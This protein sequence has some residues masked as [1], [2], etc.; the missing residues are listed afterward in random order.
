MRAAEGSRLLGI[1]S[2]QPDRAVSAADLGR[3]FGKPAAWINARTGIRSLRR[4]RARADLFALAHT[5]AVRAL[6]DANCTSAGIDLVIAAS[7]SVSGGTKEL[8]RSIA[9]GVGVR[10]GH[11]DLNAACSG[12]CYA[13]GVADGLIRTGAARY[14]LIVAAEAMSSI[15]DEADLGTSIIFAD[16]AGAAVIGPSVPAESGIGPTVWGSDGAGA[17]LIEFESTGRYLRMQGQEVFRWAVDTVPGIASAACDRAGVEL[18]DLDVLV[19][20]QANLRIIDAVRRRLDLR[21]DVVVATDITE[22]GNTSAASVP[23][24]LDK[25]RR[26][27]AVRPGNLALLLGFG[28]GLAHAAQVVRLP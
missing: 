16:G 3:P 4:V 11:L 27:G 8:A 9:H 26:C 28:A 19:P 17:G 18:R 1:G 6:D 20:H 14:V 23:I 21:D 7:C 24:A 12:F 22:S 13:L 15:V 2:A 5:A 10:G 25:L